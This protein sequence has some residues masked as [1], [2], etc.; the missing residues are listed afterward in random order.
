MLKKL[1]VLCALVTIGVIRPSGRETATAMSEL[2]SWVTVLPS[3][4]ALMP[5]LLLSRLTRD[6]ILDLVAYILGGGDSAHEMFG[7]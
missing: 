5:P 3:K 6:E 7:R 2:S 1:I 4:V